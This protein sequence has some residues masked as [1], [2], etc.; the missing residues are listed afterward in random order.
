[1]AVGTRALAGSLVAAG[2]VE[3]RRV[4]GALAASRLSGPDV[5]LQDCTPTDDTVNIE[6]ENENC[7]VNFLSQTYR[8]FSGHQGYVM[9]NGEHKAS[10]PHRLV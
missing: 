2:A 4:E 6:Q 9:I 3:S 7:I 5:L 1:M 10:I 8:T